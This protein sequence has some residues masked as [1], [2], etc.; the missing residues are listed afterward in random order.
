MQ[1]IEVAARIPFDNTVTEAMIHNMPVVEYSHD[2]VS[3]QIEA[4]WEKVSNIV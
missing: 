1:G 2:G 3:H 4:L